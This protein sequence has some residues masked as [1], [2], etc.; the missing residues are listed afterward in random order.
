[1]LAVL[2]NGEA[3][4]QGRVPA[5]HVGQNGG[6][7]AVAKLSVHILL[8]WAI[9]A[10]FVAYRA[11][12]DQHARALTGYGTCTAHSVRWTAMYTEHH[13]VFQ[14]LVHQFSAH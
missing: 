8:P 6:C 13:V 9:A 11:L 5:Q 4:T 2:V 1:V 14:A 12:S 10:N 7:W 3:D